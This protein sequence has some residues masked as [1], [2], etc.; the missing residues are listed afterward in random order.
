MLRIRKA[1]RRANPEVLGSHVFDALI[2][3]KTN[4]WN[5]YC[6]RYSME[7]VKYLDC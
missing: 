1:K 7:T 5:Q 4:D 6:L 3:Y 2:E